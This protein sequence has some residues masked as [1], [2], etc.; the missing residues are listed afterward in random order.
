MGDHLKHM[1]RQIEKLNND[2][3]IEKH[4]EEKNTHGKEHGN[5]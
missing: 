4:R 3:L 5:F 1:V 2:N